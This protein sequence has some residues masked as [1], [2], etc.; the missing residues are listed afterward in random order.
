M[1][2]LASFSSNCE[3]KFWKTKTFQASRDHVIE[4][5]RSN[6]YDRWRSI[7]PLPF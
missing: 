4:R 1:A 7:I 3:D 6:R 2:G 5:I